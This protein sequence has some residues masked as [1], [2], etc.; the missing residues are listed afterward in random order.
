MAHD[1]AISRRIRTFLKDHPPFAFC[2]DMQIE[3]VMGAIS[4]RVIHQNEV[5]FKAGDSPKDHFFMVRKGAINIEDERD[6]LRVLLDQCGEGDI[7]GIR[8]IIAESPYLLDSTA[9]ETSILYQ[10]PF[11]VFKPLTDAN[12]QVSQYMMKRFAAG[13]SIRDTVMPL[14]D[15]M[16]SDLL[17][18]SVTV[19]FPAQRSLVTG[20][21]EMSVFEGCQIMVEQNVSSLIILDENQL[22]VGIITDRDIRKWVAQGAERQPKIH[23]IMS[24][25]VQCLSQHATLPEIQTVMMDT[26]Y[27]H[28]CLTEDGTSL[29]QVTGMVTLQ[30]MISAYSSDPVMLIKKIKNASTVAALARYRNKAD[31][32]AFRVVSDDIHPEIPL[33]IGTR[34]GKALTAKVIDMHDP[35]WPGATSDQWSF[36]AM[37]SMARGE[38]ILPTDQDNGLI[39]QDEFADKKEQLLE[40]ALHIN[41]DLETVGYE[42]CPANMMAS[43]PLWCHTVSEYRQKV[44]QWLHQPGPDEVLLTATFFDFSHVHGNPQW[45]QEVKSTIREE[46][47][48][49]SIYLRFLAQQSVQYPPP[50]SFFRKLLVEKEGE[51]RDR[52][53]IKLRGLAPLVDAARVLSLSEKYIESSSTVDRLE[54]MKTVD[55]GN[56]KLYEDAIQAFYLMLTLRTKWALKNQDSGRYIKVEDLSKLEMIELREAFQPTRALQDKISRK[57]KLGFL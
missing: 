28:I 19:S 52:F 36:F 57:Y 10:I 33:K 15:P 9:M 25:P 55:P 41:Q 49:D 37:G 1:F 51:Y 48:S 34:I 3:K 46:L 20:H 4:V 2:D 31:Q 50:V 5:V 53:D 16:T 38:Q 26:G 18:Q 54:F 30:D 44:R 7:F 35:P 27:H 56:I 47:S 6:G 32:L 14:N 24:H 22:P 8:P 21:P 42:K 43:N 11:S 39:I 17:T 29:S 23:Q 13:K 45:V 40:W 12:P